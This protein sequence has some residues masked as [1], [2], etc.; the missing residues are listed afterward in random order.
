MPGRVVDRRGLAP[1]K[2]ARGVRLPVLKGAVRSC[3]PK[4]GVRIPS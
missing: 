4:S 3:R 2:E 1:E